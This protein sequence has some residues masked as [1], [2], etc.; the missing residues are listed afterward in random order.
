M[1]AFNE[2]ILKTPLIRI[3]YILY[4]IAYNKVILT[5]PVYNRF[6]KCVCL[7]VTDTFKP[8]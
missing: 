6:L 3:L 5:L 4:I 1:K 2:K 8:Q 7:S